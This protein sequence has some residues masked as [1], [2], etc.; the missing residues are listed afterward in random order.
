[1]SCRF[2]GSKCRIWAI[3][4]VLRCLLLYVIRRRQGW[5]AHFRPLQ[6]EAD[7][8]PEIRIAWLP[9][10]TPDKLIGWRFFSWHSIEDLFKIQALTA[11]TFSRNAALEVIRIRGTYFVCQG[12]T[13]TLFAPRWLDDAKQCPV[14]NASCGRGVRGIFA[15]AIHA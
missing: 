4:W 8:H 13:V 9:N 2:C 10:W 7:F 5:K 11:K 1:M 14:T 6:R 15:P 12:A 3:L